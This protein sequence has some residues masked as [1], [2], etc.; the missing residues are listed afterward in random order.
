MSN[1]ANNLDIFYRKFKLLLYDK[2]LSDL[3][4]ENEDALTMQEVVH[5]EIIVALNGPTIKTFAEHAKLSDPN[6]AYRVQKLISKGYIRKEQSS[7]D[8]REFHLVPTDKYAEHIGLF[9]DYIK[10]VSDRIEKHFSPEDV[11]RFDEIL[12]ITCRELTPEIDS[13]LLGRK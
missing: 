3:G 7:S 2:A 4:S 8:R 9:S 12:E 6:A 10:M 13:S 5:M 11:A 1:I